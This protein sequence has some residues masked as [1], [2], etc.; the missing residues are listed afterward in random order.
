MKKG[1][2]FRDLVWKLVWKMTYFGLKPGQH[3]KN[4][5]AHLHQ[6]LPRVPPL[7]GAIVTW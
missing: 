5:A 4:R 3:L 1:M 7:P 2:D 6:E